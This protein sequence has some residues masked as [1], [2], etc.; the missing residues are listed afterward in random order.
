MNVRLTRTTGIRGAARRDDAGGGGEIERL[1][2]R[3]ADLLD[4]R[5]W[6]NRKD[7]GDSSREAVEP[8]RR[9]PRRLGGRNR[10]GVA[11]PDQR[12][13]IARRRKEPP[14]GTHVA[15]DQGD[16]EGDRDGHRDGDG[17]GDFGRAQPTNPRKHDD[18]LR[19]AR[20]ERKFAVNMG[21]GTRREAGRGSRRGETRGGAP[22]ESFERTRTPVLCKTVV[23]ARQTTHPS[24][25][26]APP[27]RRP[28]SRVFFVEDG[29]RTGDRLFTDRWAWLKIPFPT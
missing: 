1:E 20:A 25:T 9:P 22:G 6:T 2:P 27:A 7:P 28:A 13:R 18:R 29:A 16:G 11:N 23:A 4:A 12:R 19:N 5:A 14:H 3:V 26:D 24:T 21:E 15:R 17:V 10:D 8:E